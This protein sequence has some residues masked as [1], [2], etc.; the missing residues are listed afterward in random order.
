M[1]ALSGEHDTH[2]WSCHRRRLA[3]WKTRTKMDGV[4]SGA[5]E[6]SRLQRF[7]WHEQIDTTAPPPKC[8]VLMRKN[9]MRC[10][11]GCKLK[12][13][14]SRTLRSSSQSTLP[15]YNSDAFKT[16]PERSIFGRIFKRTW[17][18]Q[19]TWRADSCGTRRDRSACTRPRQGWTLHKTPAMVFV[20][21][22]LWLTL[23]ER[24]RQFKM[25]L[26]NCKVDSREWRPAGWLRPTFAWCLV[27][28]RAI[29]AKGK[30]TSK[31]LR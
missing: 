27:F 21:D 8:R 28:D 19:G 9:V 18:K 25:V 15:A 26:C 12:P 17:E 11:W 31:G 16:A 10:N 30:T 14:A 5:E 24:N 2:C 3:T 29:L 4:R 22:L 23:L 6:R 13:A 20:K 7:P 1:K